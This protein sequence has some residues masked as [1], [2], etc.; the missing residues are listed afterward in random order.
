VKDREIFFDSVINPPQ[1][2]EKLKN[3]FKQYQELLNGK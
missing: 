1:P 2:N 3:A